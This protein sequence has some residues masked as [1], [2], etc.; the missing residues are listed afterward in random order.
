MI[1]LL[2]NDD[3]ELRWE[4]I[5]FVAELTEVNGLRKMPINRLHDFHSAVNRGL[6]REIVLQYTGERTDLEEGYHGRV[7]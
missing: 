7:E 5:N 6:E 1:D 4:I 2:L 3:P